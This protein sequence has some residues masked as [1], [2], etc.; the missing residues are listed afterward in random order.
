MDKS[1]SPQKDLDRTKRSFK[2]GLEIPRNWR[3]ILRIDEA[4]GNTPWKDGAENKADALIHLKCFTFKSPNFKSPKEYKYCRLHITYDVKPDLTHKA[5][6]VYNNSRI[7]P[8]R[9]VN[10]GHSSQRIFSPPIGF[11]C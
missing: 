4:A 9:A 7:D 8:P 11:D 10:Q 3:D 6:L 1:G 5:R 2:F